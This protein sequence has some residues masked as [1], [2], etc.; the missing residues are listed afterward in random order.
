MKK[1]TFLTMLVSLLGVTAF[2][3]QA[4]TQG[5]STTI[6]GIVRQ[7][8]TAIRKAPAATADK[9]LV[10]PPATAT[11]ETWY[12]IDGNLYVNT[13][14]GAVAY[15]PEIQV[16]I[17]GTDIYLQGMAYW[18]PD[19]WIKGTISEATATFPCG[20]F[21]GEDE[22][23]PEYIC[24]TNDVETLADN[25]VFT[26]D[27]TAGT[28]TSQTIYIL[29]NSVPDDISPYCYWITPVFSKNAPGGQGL[30]E[31]PEGLETDEWAISAMNNFGEP[32]SGY[33]NIGFDGNDCYMQGFCHYLPESWIKGTLEGNTITFPGDQYFGPY[34][35]DAYTHYE[36][37]LRPEDVV[38][39]YDAEAGKMTAEGEIYVR[40]AVRNYKGDVYNDPVLTKVIE[41][42]ATPATPTISQIYDATT[43]PVVMFT[44]PT[45]DTDGNA[46]ASSK[47]FF[48]FFKDVEQEITDVTFD[49]ADYSGLTEA[50]T[51]FPYGFTSGEEISYNYMYLKQADYNTWN[52]IGLQTIYTGGGEE[53]KSE[54]FWLDIK[55]YEKATF[56]FNAMTDEPCSSGD[57][58]S[59]DITEDRV[60]TSNGVTLTVSPKTEE[61]TT[62]NR[63][64]S[65]K[66]G[67][68]LRVYSGTLTFEAP[69]G[70]VITKMIFNNG[71]WNDGNSADSGAF[72]GNVWTGEAQK[73]VVTIAGN[74]QLNSIEVYPADYVPTAVEVPEGLVTDTYIF[75]ARSEK[76]YYDPADLTLWVKAGFDGDDVYI[77]G[78]AADYNSSVAELW[79][80][81][82]KNEAGQYVIPANQFMG[83]VAFWMSTIDCYFTAVDAEGNMVDAVL[84]Y[85][86]EKG[87]FTT[88][89]TLALNAMLTELYPY[90][91]FTGVTITKFNEVAATPADPTMNS[92]TFDEWSHYIT[93]IIPQ[94][95][96][97][98]ETLNPQ[99]LFYT[100]WIDKG[101]ETVPYVFSPDMYWGFDGDTTELPWS[102]YYSSWDGTHSIYFYDEAEVFD[103]W[104]RVGVQSIYYGCDEARK[105]NISWIETPFYTGISNVNVNAG[106]NVIYNV[107][108]QRIYAPAKGLNI[109]NGKKVIIK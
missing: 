50:M 88:D 66:N 37:Y 81:A 30:V 84:D 32:V 54:V 34:D 4:T 89:Q 29:E 27:A 85:D 22:Y 56:D 79:V 18:F 108:G 21:V 35:A 14:S 70:K 57:D 103:A 105:S 99:K 3:Q 83:S 64:W 100:I 98:G 5:P 42:A 33:V 71:K 52:K 23:G 78:L 8:Q 19:G 62:P 16:A 9:E 104:A 1:I 28:L 13:M 47:L 41:K 25:I 60:F 86:A 90:E 69:V 91:T 36:F 58:N 51:I 75:K 7:S 17:D 95:G 26:Y 11:V 2:A 87:E 20:Q 59:G 82:T 24:A 45:V 97:E 65:T 93:F 92:L 31:A 102:Q 74:T 73:V 55:P 107:A 77:Q 72:E 101:Y 63:F 94:E 46:V 44:I 38:F 96:T 10:T 48:Q 53:N 109:I 6:K 40:E 12:T 106:E 39:T 15:Q 49:P 43:G 76:Q 61:A 68:Q 67:P 80:K